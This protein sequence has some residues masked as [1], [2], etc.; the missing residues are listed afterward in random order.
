MKLKRLDDDNPYR[1]GTIPSSYI[2][3]CW[4][5]EQDRVCEKV[6]MTSSMLKV[7]VKV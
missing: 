5:F 6:K 3:R 1:K 7:I 4:A 2:E